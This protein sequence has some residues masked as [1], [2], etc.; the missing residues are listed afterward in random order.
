[1]REKLQKKV[2]L[3]DNDFLILIADRNRHVRDFLQRELKN[4]GFRIE[5]AKDDR[6]VLQI[7][8]GDIPPALLVLDLDLPYTGGLLLLKDI[9]RWNPQ[10]PI[11]IH[12][13]T[14]NNVQHLVAQGVS[15]VV[16]KTGNIENLKAV[17]TEVLQKHY[18][19][20]CGKL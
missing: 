16:A 14:T 2:V 3:M 19:K 17:I 9:K 18:P 11:V 20:R 8:K 10:L 6:S 1:M 7:V 12:T 5:V 13:L 15:A 4:E